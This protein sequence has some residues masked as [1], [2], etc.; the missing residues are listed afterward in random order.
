MKRSNKQSQRTEKYEKLRAVLK[1]KGH[2]LIVMQDFPDPDAMGASAALRELANARRVNCSFGHGGTIGRA[3]N[4]E[5]AKYMGLNLRQVGELDLERFDLV[6]TVD[7]QPGQGNNSLPA[8]VV[9]DIVIDHHPVRR[10]TRSAA[11]TDVRRH[12][13][14][15]CTILYEYLQEA[16]IVPEPPLATGMLYGIRSDTQDLGREATQADIEAYLSL[17]PI[18]NKRML[19]QIENGWVPTG[20]FRMLAKALAETRVCGEC[21]VSNLG[22]IENPDMIGEVADLLLRNENSVWA[23]AFGAFQGRVLLSLRTSLPDTD[24]GKVMRRLVGRRGSGGGHH[25]SAGGQIPLKTDSQAERRRI[26]NDIR[27]RFRRTVCACQDRPRKLI[28]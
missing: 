10:T 21:I 8:D 9:P 3:E 12:Y 19:G 14:S 6:A 7:T 5:L 4:R 16:K 27:Q 20:Y 11:F 25:A 23:L 26:D 15:T 17:Y 18:A 2:M 22:E 24:A 13:G 1:G 28:P